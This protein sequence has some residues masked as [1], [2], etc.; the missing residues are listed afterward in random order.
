MKRSRQTIEVYV[1]GDN[2]NVKAGSPADVLPK[3]E[4]V[5]ILT[6][7]SYVFSRN[8]FKKVN[9]QRIIFLPEHVLA[10]VVSRPVQRENLSSKPT[11][12]AP[13]ES[14]G[15]RKQIATNLPAQSN[16]ASKQAR[17]GSATQRHLHAFT[18]T[19]RNKID[20]HNA[21]TYAIKHPEDVTISHWYPD[22][23]EEAKPQSLT[24]KVLG[25]VL[26]GLAISAVSAGFVNPHL[27]NLREQR[28]VFDTTE[29]A[30][31]FIAPYEAVGQLVINATSNIAKR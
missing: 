8:D 22:S 15:V 6:T 17:V 14:K 7:S 21:V 12:L 29:Y 11:P 20:A 24:L 30:K 26:S 25:G 18:E 27:Q 2:K 3:K 1:T 13:P 28:P 19:V 23:S 31:D 16:S 9:G 4:L 5:Q 10:E